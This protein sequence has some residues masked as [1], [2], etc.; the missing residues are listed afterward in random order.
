LS[1]SITLRY[2]AVTYSTNH[3]ALGR[4]PRDC[5]PGKMNKR[6]AL[7]PPSMEAA[8]SLETLCVESVVRQAL[9]QPAAADAFRDEILAIA[10]RLRRSDPK[11]VRPDDV[12]CFMDNDQDNGPKVPTCINL[13]FRLLPDFLQILARASVDDDDA[14]KRRFVHF[15]EGSLDFPNEAIRRIDEFMG[16]RMDIVDVVSFGNK[17]DVQGVVR[18]LV[19]ESDDA[20]DGYQCS[21]DITRDDWSEWCS[22]CACKC[23]EL[24]WQLIYNNILPSSER[25]EQ[26]AS[27]G[28]DRDAQR[29]ATREL[30]E[31]IA[32]ARD[33]AGPR[34]LLHRVPVLTVECGQEI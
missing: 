22:D 26:Y 29:E 15:I 6:P 27:D 11:D 13:P 28:V 34:A 19:A 8:P 33:N 32:A 23:Y 2:V 12:V 24:C 14:R 4:Q 17:Y 3:A 5:L 30:E 20:P 16:L 21:E 10:P 18:D 7:S 25:A 9:A 1:N 31:A